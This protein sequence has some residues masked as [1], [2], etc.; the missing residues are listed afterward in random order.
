VQAQVQTINAGPFNAMSKIPTLL[1]LTG[2][3]AVVGIQ[4]AATAAD[5]CVQN[6][7]SATYR[8]DNPATSCALPVSPESGVSGSKEVGAAATVR[9]QLRAEDGTVY[10]ALKR[11]SALAGWQISWEIPVDFPIEIEDDASGT[12]E[13]AIQRVLTALRVSDYPPHPCFHDNRV[14][15]VVRRIQGNDDE[16]K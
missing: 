10:A 6:P 13:S 3:I 14:L 15:R 4:N 12:Y 8:S 7:A 9:W 11:W 5:L 1:I 2:F 16:C